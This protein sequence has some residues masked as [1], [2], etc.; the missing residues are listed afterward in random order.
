MGHPMELIDTIE[1]TARGS[2]FEILVLREKASGAHELF[3]VKQG[4][5]MG[6]PA[7]RA[8]PG[9]SWRTA[10]LDQLVAEAIADIDSNAGSCY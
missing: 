7:R 10:P 1:H 2:R 6:Y 8:G 3:V 4:S 5:G 9:D